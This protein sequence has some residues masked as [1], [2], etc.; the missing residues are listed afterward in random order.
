[1]KKSILV[2]VWLVGSFGVL[3]PSLQSQE[4]TAAKQPVAPVR[5]VTDDYY[6]TKIVDNY[7]YMENLKDPEVQS[8]FKNQNDYTRATLANIPGR[9]K[10]L[11][12]IKELDQSVPVTVF[13]VQRL[14]GDLYFYRKVLAGENIPKLYVRKGSNAFLCIFFMQAVCGKWS[15]LRKSRPL[16]AFSMTQSNTV[17]CIP[18]LLGVGWRFCRPSPYL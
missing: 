16:C 17:V 1:M 15:A 6:G 11:A 14:P 12:R 13:G 5:P 8:W 3:A 10:L 2:L 18:D 4:K 9:D 7:R